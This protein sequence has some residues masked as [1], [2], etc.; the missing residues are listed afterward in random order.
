L[1]DHV[2][3]EEASFEEDVLVL[4]GLENKAEDS[5]SDFLADF[6]GVGSVAEDFRFNNWD[7]AVVLADGSVSS[8]SPCVFLDGA[9]SWASSGFV[10]LEDSSPF[11]ESAAHVVVL[12]AHISKRVQTLGGGFFI[13]EWNVLNT[14]V[15]LD[16]WNNSL[17]GE[18]LAEVNTVLG[19]LFGGF[20]EKD[21]TRN[22]IFE[23][24]GSEE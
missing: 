5:F 18:E 8:E 15:D 17:V 21:D 14:F 6:D 24:W 3:L 22:V 13:G 7:K 10:N 11:S 2:W 19:G 4:E 23:S 20:R 16:S 12:L 9:V 1:G